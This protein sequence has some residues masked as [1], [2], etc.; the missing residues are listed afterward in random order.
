[1]YLDMEWITNHKMAARMFPSPPINRL[2]LWTILPLAS[3]IMSNIRDRKRQTIDC[4]FHSSVLRLGKVNDL[5]YR[6]SL[7]AVY[8]YLRDRVA[9]IDDA[10]ITTALSLL[11]FKWKWVGCCLFIDLLPFK[12]LIIQP[13]VMKF[14]KHKSVVTITVTLVS[15]TIGEQEYFSQSL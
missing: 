10:D 6:F 5:S 8:H 9:A 14:M 15:S 3:G 7:A 2:H 1:M 4:Q 11:I 12:G 13:I